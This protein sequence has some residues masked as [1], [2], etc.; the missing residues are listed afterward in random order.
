MD[1]DYAN[2]L[3]KAM[4]QTEDFA[5]TVSPSYMKIIEGKILPKQ[6]KS[7]AGNSVDSIYLKVEFTTDD[8]GEIYEIRGHQ[9]TGF[10]E[11]EY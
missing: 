6:G 9:R 10:F 3:F 7:K 2:L 8:P 1:V 4:N 11:D 5:A